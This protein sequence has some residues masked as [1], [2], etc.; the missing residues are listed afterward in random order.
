M[1]V[2]RKQ[3]KLAAQRKR[4]GKER[5]PENHS[6]KRTRF[7]L[8]G[9]PELSKGSWNKILAQGRRDYTFEIEHNV[10]Q[11]T[12]D[13]DI[14]KKVIF[15]AWRSASYQKDYK[16][17]GDSHL[18]NVRAKRKEDGRRTRRTL[19]HAQEATQQEVAGWAE[20]KVVAREVAQ[21]RANENIAMP[22]LVAGGAVAAALSPGAVGGPLP[23]MGGEAPNSTRQNKL[24]QS[25]KENPKPEH[26][27]KSPRKIG[28]V[29]RPR[30]TKRPGAQ[31]GGTCGAKMGTSYG[32]VR[33]HEAVCLGA[34]QVGNYKLIRKIG[35]GTFSEVYL[36]SRVT[37]KSR[38]SMV[39][40]K[41]LHRTNSPCQFYNELV[42]LRCLGSKPSSPVVKLLDA[43]R[44]EDA[45]TLVQEHI[46]HCDFEQRL[47][48]NSLE[49]I[50][51]YLQ[52]LF[53]T[54]QYLHSYNVMHRDIKPSNFLYSFKTGQFKLVDFGLA[55]I[56]GQDCHGDRSA[57]D[58]NIWMTKFA[59][60]FDFPNVQSAP[61]VPQF[62]RVEAVDTVSQDRV[63][64]LAPGEIQRYNLGV[65]L[66]S[67]KERQPA[68]EGARV[69]CS[70]ARQG[71]TRGYKAPEVLWRCTKE[72]TVAIDVWAAGV[73]M[74]QILSCRYPFF[75]AKDDANAFAEIAEITPIA[76][77]QRAVCETS[78]ETSYY[79]TCV[80]IVKATQLRP[81]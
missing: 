62:R 40:I 69:R 10:A 39:A 42:L 71:G 14:K 1:E 20:E 52:A 72:Q 8:S 34:N 2:V 47:M 24:E 73:I 45:C 57:N 65:V 18:D 12:D 33:T 59:S 64:I 36:A 21:A 9:V 55:H 74:L 3:Q 23:A 30:R 17:A 67:T 46:E 44:V 61:R 49:D 56:V 53:K 7:V 48:L 16:Y 32:Q 80:R 19:K 78:M 25:S 76:D 29:A 37:P 5:D 11:V 81:V 38:P 58:L 22:M 68:K 54:L 75:R 26:K 6:P 70:E 41:K 60:N 66:K 50:T 79:R 31:Y 13:N 28:A 77:L 15:H 51:K 43:F 4:R 35:Q 63:R 27:L